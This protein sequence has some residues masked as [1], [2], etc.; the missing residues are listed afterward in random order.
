[1]KEN[2][3]NETHVHVEHSTEVEKKRSIEDDLRL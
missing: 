2:G 1:M 3:K